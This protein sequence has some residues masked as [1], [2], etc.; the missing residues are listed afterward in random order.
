MPTQDRTHE[1]LSCVQS[2]KTRSSVP[3]RRDP[4]KQRLLSESTQ[5]K[6]EFSRMASAIG[7]DISST[8]T[9]L[10]KLAQLSELTYIIKQDIASINKQI[11]QLQAYVKQKDG[12]SGSS[13]QVEEHNHN[14]VM[15]LQS[16]L[17]TTSMSFK[18][19]LEVRTQNMKESK[20]RTEQF[21]Y[22]TSSAASTPPP[23]SAPTYLSR[24]LRTPLT[25]DP[26]GD[27]SASRFDPKGKGRAQQNGDL[28]AMN[29]D[30]AE[31]GQLM[32]SNSFQQMELVEQQDNYIQ[33]RTTAIESI[34][35]TIAELGQIFT[36][37][38]TMVAEQ[39]ETVQR[40]DA[41]TMDIA[42]NVSGAQRELLKYYASI[43]S[44]R[45]LMLK[46]FGVLIVF[47]LVFI[48]VS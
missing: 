23:S 30:A 47:F 28:L 7:K 5:S 40:I 37:L 43:S 25:R 1:F 44:N 35:S 20:S 16:K 12:Q 13:K 32:Q 11:A 15:L 27:G 45:W 9:K 46:V 3:S 48:L 41:D 29:L 18:D 34:E 26:M 2:I 8:T 38:A 36:Q 24:S 39:R 21:M 19:V 17:A 4:V 42:T 22:S 33:T 10:A 31:E 6:S 14:V